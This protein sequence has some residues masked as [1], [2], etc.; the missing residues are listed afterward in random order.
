M[1]LLT[2]NYVVMPTPSEMS[3]GVMDL[4]KAERNANGL[5]LIERIA[6]KRK[7]EC[8]WAFLT[9]AQVRDLLLAVTPVFFN[10]VYID[11][12]VGDERI[13]AFYVGDRNMG[14]LDYFN[15]VIRYK[16]F[17]MNFIER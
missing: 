5:M 13:G 12:I 3:V 14:V 4:S 9:Q 8:T 1:A 2:I 15:G 7:L 11:P 17:S 6:T 10:I 16:D